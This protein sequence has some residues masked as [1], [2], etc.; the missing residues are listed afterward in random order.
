MVPSCANHLPTVGWN[1]PV[2]QTEG[3]RIMVPSLNG[4]LEDP[5]I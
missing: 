5:R 3:L 4:I 1:T 2:P